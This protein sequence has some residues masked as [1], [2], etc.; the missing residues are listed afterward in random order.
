MECQNIETTLTMFFTAYMF[1]IYCVYAII[2][3]WM[4]YNNTS[5]PKPN[6]PKKKK[7]TVLKTRSEKFK[8]MVCMAE[9][10]RLKSIT[11]SHKNVLQKIAVITKKLCT[12]QFENISDKIKK[13]IVED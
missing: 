2:V 8:T 4:C 5:Q 11:K 7:L 10:S 3:M 6:L 13:D 1:E 9:I 12:T